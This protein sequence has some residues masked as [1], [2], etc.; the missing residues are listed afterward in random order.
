M[1]LSTNEEVTA[2][3]SKCAGGRRFRWLLLV[4]RRQQ[5]CQK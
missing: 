4:E 3:F 5:I 1:I 2:G